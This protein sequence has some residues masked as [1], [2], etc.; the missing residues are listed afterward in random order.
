MTPSFN[1]ENI[2][3]AEIH[4]KLFCLYWEQ[5]VMC[6]NKMVQLFYKKNFDN[7]SSYKYGN[8]IIKF[9]FTL[10]NFF[11]ENANAL[12]ISI[13]IARKEFHTKFFILY[14]YFDSVKFKS[15]FHYPV[16][17]AVKLL[18]SWITS[19]VSWLNAIKGAYK[20]DSSVQSFFS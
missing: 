12:L 6:S 3:K 2:C 9:L 16:V 10:T 17:N 18:A 13:S 20:L 8:K 1:F 7:Y 15:S 19:T 11:T 5:K 4:E 14:V